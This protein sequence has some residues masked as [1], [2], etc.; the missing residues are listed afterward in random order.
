M[1]NMLRSTYCLGTSLA[2]S[3]MI[4]DK[5]RDNIFSNVDNQTEFRK[6]SALLLPA[7]EVTTYE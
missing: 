3:E 5:N 6:L 7:E 1:E 4:K 2:E